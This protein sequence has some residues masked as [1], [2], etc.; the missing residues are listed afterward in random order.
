MGWGMGTDPAGVGVDL[1][2]VPFRFLEKVDSNEVVWNFSFR[3]R[4]AHSMRKW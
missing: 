4:K 1:L 2:L 3:E